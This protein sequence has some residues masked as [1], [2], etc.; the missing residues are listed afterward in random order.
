MPFT[1]ILHTSIISTH[2]CFVTTFIKTPHIYENMTIWPR[3]YNEET[4][5]GHTGEPETAP[6]EIFLSPLNMHHCTLI[7]EH[8][9]K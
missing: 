9:T 3:D 2:K 7:M 4:R 8:P 1:T 5:W 6:R